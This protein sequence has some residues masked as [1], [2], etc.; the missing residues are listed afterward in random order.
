MSNFEQQA[1]N[2]LLKNH[3]ETDGFSYTVPSPDSYPYQWLWDSCFH[4]QILSYY[5]V[6]LAKK[7]LLSL[8]SKQFKNGMIPHMI[9]WVPSKKIQINWGKKDTSTI[10]QPPI[11]AD[12]VLKIYEKDLDKDFLKKVYPNL[13]RFYIYI[14]EN[15]DS[16]GNHLMGLINP[17]ESGEDT[18]PRF[19]IPLKAP[20]LITRQDHHKLRLKLVEANKECNFG[21]KCMKNFFWVKDVPFN[22]FMIKNLRSLAKMAS[23]LNEEKD[24]DYFKNQANLISE[25]MKKYMLEDGIY[26]SVYQSDNEATVDYKKIKVKTWAMFTPL[27]AKLVTQKEAEF[28]VDEHLLNRKEFWLKYPVPTVSADEPSF[29]PE[30]YWRGPTWIAINFFIFHG[31]MNYG[32]LDIAKEIYQVSKFLVERQGF[33]EYFNPLTGEGLGAKN[34]T[35]GA[36]ILDMEKAL[37]I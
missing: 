8:L 28:L 3:R 12:T 17:D 35:W 20:A 9:Y 15:R 16:R 18:S 13:K 26:W 5:N 33:R 19:D 23:I 34:F 22:V 37:K 14:L 29:N 31:L 4:A 36:L 32:F 24:A 7:E 6:N 11:I 10:T 30:G 25:A 1:K 2:I 27:F 21:T